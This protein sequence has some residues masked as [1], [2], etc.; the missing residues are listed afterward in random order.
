M[1]RKPLRNGSKSRVKQKTEDRSTDSIVKV[2]IVSLKDEQTKTET[3][4]DDEDEED[5][6]PME[7]DIESESIPITFEFNDMREDYYA[8]IATLMRKIIP[9]NEA[10]ELATI[11]SEQVAVGTVITCEDGDDVFAYAT[12]MPLISLQ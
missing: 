3:D 7:G 2:P 4:S 10:T 1:K 6:I 9:Q 12:V 11:V 8:G 5:D